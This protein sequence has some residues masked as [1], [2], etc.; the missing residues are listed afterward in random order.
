MDYRANLETATTY[1][2]AGLMEKGVESLCK[3]YNCFQE[4]G[5]DADRCTFLKLTPLM[6][7]VAMENGKGR[8][9]MRFIEEGLSV[10]EYDCDL[11]FLRAMVFWDR[12]CYDEMLTS[13]LSYLASLSVQDLSVKEYR[14]VNDLSI[15]K[16]FNDL[17]PLAYKQSEAHQ[18][19]SRVVKKLS[20]KTRDPYF[21]RLV[22][23]IG[24][25]DKTRAEVSE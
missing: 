17:A 25:I 24:D 6:A 11:L 13:L 4:D 15:R 3:I 14:Y 7:K 10:D 20:E 19:I 5:I 23:V 8:E 16:V 2:E 21:E 18:E 22:Q 12:G 1:L 9:A